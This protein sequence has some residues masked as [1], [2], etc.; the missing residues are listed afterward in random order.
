M[1]QYIQ[2]RNNTYHFRFKVPH[3]LRYLINKTEITRTLKTDS[4]QLACIK[5][6]SK[7]SL[8]YQLR[9]TATDNYD[10]LATLLAKLMD[11]S[12]H[13][14]N[15]DS[16]HEIS[17]AETGQQLFNTFMQINPNSPTPIRSKSSNKIYE[18]S[19]FPLEATSNVESPYL[20]SKAWSDFADFKTWNDKRTKEYTYHYN[21][22]M[23][24]W[25]NV[26]ITTINKQ[27][28]RKCLKAYELMPQGNKKPFN[29]LTVAERLNYPT[30]EIP[31]ED[32]ISPKTVK[33]LL[34]TLQ[35]FFSTFL[36]GEKDCFMQS[37]TTNVKYTIS[38]KRFG[39]YSD[40]EIQAFESEADNTKQLW[41]R[42]ALLL[43]IYTGARRG[44]V[45]KFMFD[46]VKFDDEHHIYY[47]ELL[48]G[49]TLAAKRKIPVHPR[50]I[51]KGILKVSSIE[52][53][54]KT[55]TDY[56]NKIRDE[57]KIPLS[58]SEGSKRIYHSF[59]HTFITKGISKGVTVEHLKTV[60][61]HSKNLGIT[62]RYIHGLSLADLNEVILK[63]TY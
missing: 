5:V 37:P 32:F 16:R 63:I 10:E 47:F 11:F 36:T 12:E 45:V 34:K 58:D 3:H 42:W 51:E 18:K 15:I 23:A 20:L 8:I 46:G 22:L 57:L 30:D 56:I 50:L 59:R 1:K 43:A 53:N 52:I 39:V 9:N 54:A 27:A 40:G 44:E 7:F 35:G 61:G 6:S 24:L 21:F 48:E 31:E 29:K 4:H 62:S 19:D 41:Q 28:I 55:I 13:R 33:S 38:E 49:K 14:I 60:V 2:L 17:T 26:D 25:G